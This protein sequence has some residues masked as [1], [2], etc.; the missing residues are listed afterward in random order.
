MC[1]L[2]LVC[3][4]HGGISAALLSLSSA[5]SQVLS[6]ALQ[7]MIVL[8]SIPAHAS[9]PDLLTA[10]ARSA[11]FAAIKLRRGEKKASLHM[12]PNPHGPRHYMTSQALFG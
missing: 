12:F 8:L 3:L 2:E 6:S 7:T 11:E 10:A 9:V 5:D 4:A 1:I